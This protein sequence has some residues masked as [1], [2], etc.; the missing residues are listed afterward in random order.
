MD[1]REL[2]DGH[3][4]GVGGELGRAER[5]DV[6][7]RAP[8]RFANPGP[9]LAEHPG[10]GEHR[11]TA[12]DFFAKVHNVRLVAVSLLAD[13]VGGVLNELAQ[14]VHVVLHGERD[15]LERRVHHLGPLG[16]PAGQAAVAVSLAEKLVRGDEPIEIL[17]HQHVTDGHLEL[18]EAG[19]VVPP[20][21]V[22]TFDLLPVE[23]LHGDVE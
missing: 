17:A 23:L 13:D 2:G 4:A 10:H 9:G 21:Q 16:G 15:G 14:V 5:G 20:G 18:A 1:I 12:D 22:E 3:L 19:V 11:V 8:G 6:P 7:R